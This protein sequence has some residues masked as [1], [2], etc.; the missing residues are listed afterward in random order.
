MTHG[1]GAREETS[2][3]CHSGRFL[4]VRAPRRAPPAPP[5]GPRAPGFFLAPLVLYPIYL[6]PGNTRYALRDRRVRLYDETLA[7]TAGSTTRHA[8]REERPLPRP[9]QIWRS[10]LP[11]PPLALPP[12]LWNAA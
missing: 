7:G 6:I 1:S 4:R 12:V 10:A 2:H 11:C 3:Q 5:P 9:R 8:L